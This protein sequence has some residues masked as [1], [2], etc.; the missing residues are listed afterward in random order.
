M[1]KPEHRKAAGRKGLRYDSDLTE[2]EWTLVRAA[3]TAY[4]AWRTEAADR[5]ARGPQRHFLRAVDRL[6][7]EGAAQGLPAQEHGARLSD[8]MGLGR[9]ARTHS[10]RALCGRARATRPGSKSHRRHHRQ[11]ERES[12]PQR[13]AFLDPQG[14]D[15]AKNITGRKRHVLVD[16]LGLLLSV[17]VHATDIQDRDGVRFVLDKRTRALWPFI[18]K[19]FVMPVIRARAWLWRLPARA[20]GRDRQAQRTAQVHCRS[21]AMDR[22]ENS[23]MAEQKP[24]SHARFRALHTHRCS[25]HPPCHDQ[26]L[27]RCLIRSTACP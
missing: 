13:G 3:N 8:V 19:I 7:V 25:L 22:R 1:W 18:L 20:V 24:P 4:Q 26:A 23:R 9:N 21:Q 16:T 2:E 15:A 11:P 10:S 5:C 27:L 12:G 17:A 6:S 14:F